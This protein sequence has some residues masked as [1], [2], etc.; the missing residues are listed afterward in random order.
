MTLISNSV[1]L[2]HHD[3]V[4]TQHKQATLT[5]A[6]HKEN[7]E[8]NF[9]PL[10]SMTKFRWGIYNV[11]I[12]FIRAIG[13]STQ[14]DFSI[15]LTVGDSTRDNEVKQDHEIASNV[16]FFFFGHLS[17]KFNALKNQN[18]WKLWNSQVTMLHVCV[19]YSECSSFNP[20]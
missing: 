7:V 16:I 4:N 9:F 8:D 10:L 3:K 19:I 6:V 20:F 12:N 5:H 2:V 11:K 15:L 17:S 14:H 13:H 18:R 1:S